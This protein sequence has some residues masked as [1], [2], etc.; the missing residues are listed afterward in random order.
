MPRK[1]TGKSKNEASFDQNA[2]K[3]LRR[4]QIQQKL[5]KALADLKPALGEK[6]FKRRMKKAGK[7]ISSGLTK[8]MR[9]H[10]PEV[11]KMPSQATAS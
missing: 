7:L 9:N 3:K 1:N 5:E 4:Q 10:Q 11:K 2:S 6:K 8:G